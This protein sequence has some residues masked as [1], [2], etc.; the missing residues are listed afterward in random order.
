MTSEFSTLPPDLQIINEMGRNHFPLQKSF[1]EQTA[2]L[3]LM[4]LQEESQSSESFL[5]TA[6]NQDGVP[7][8][9]FYPINSRS[10]VMDTFQS[11]VE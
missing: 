2:F 4:S 1:K 5:H 11:M 8:P 3:S 6:V 10:Q 9:I 7:N